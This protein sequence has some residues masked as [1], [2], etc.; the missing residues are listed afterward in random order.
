MFF[1]SLLGDGNHVSPADLGRGL[2]ISRAKVAQVL[3]LLRLAPEVLNAIAALGNP[4][5]GPTLWLLLPPVSIAAVTAA[6]AEFAQAIGAALVSRSSSYSTRRTGMR[7]RRCRYLREPLRFLPCYSPELQPAEHLW[8][9]DERT[10]GESPLLRA[11]RPGR[12]AGTT[13]SHPTCHA[14][15]DPRL[16]ELSLVAASLPVDHRLS[17]PRAMARGHPVQTWP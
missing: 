17:R 3:R 15:G 13:L 6:L 16:H 12:R 14:G 10:A 4:P 5:L 9:F 2:A 8:P 1:S 7:A 11:R